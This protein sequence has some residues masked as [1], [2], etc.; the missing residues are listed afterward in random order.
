[1]SLREAPISPSAAPSRYFRQ[2]HKGL[3]DPPAI[4][5]QQFRPAWRVRARLDK[6]LADDLISPQTWNAAFE[7]RATVERAF[8]GLLGSALDRIG[9]GRNSTRSGAGFERSERQLAAVRRLASARKRLGRRTETLLFT[10]LIDDLCWS[11]LGARIGCDPKTSK[12]RV[13][14]ALKALA[15]IW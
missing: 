7:Y 11:K 3:V 14:V 2:H 10:F 1:M 5:A 8:G 12:T 15:V 13:R 6:L 9:T 4:D